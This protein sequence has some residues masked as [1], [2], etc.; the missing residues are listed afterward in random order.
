MCVPKSVLG[1]NIV[2]S[3]VM[4]IFMK[5]NVDKIKF[6]EKFKSRV[7]GQL[8]DYVKP[9]STN[10]REKVLIE[11]VDSEHVWYKATGFDFSFDKESVE[12]HLFNLLYR[13][14]RHKT[15]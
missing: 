13:I 9:Y 15:W 2:F 12:F 6:L 3:V 8:I 1:K 7:S 5:K 10:S 11:M 4:F 14:T